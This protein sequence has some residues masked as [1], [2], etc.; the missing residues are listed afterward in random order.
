M[1]V[2]H[3]T[4]KSYIDYFIDSFLVDKA[5]RYDVKGKKYINTISLTWG[6]VMRF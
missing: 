3:N 6:F 1:N 5:V 2:S 4:I